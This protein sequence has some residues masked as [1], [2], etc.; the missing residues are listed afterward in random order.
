MKAFEVLRRPELLALLLAAVAAGPS[1][2]D[3]WRHAPLEV[4]SA[5]CM[6]VWLVPLGWQVMNHG[7][8]P[9]S[10]HGM[11]FT[12][13]ALGCLV[14]GGV[15]DLNFLNHCALAL[16]GAAV[17][18]QWGWR[19]LCWLAVAPAWMPVTGWLAAGWPIAP[20]VAAR[21][22]GCAVAATIFFFAKTTAADD[23]THNLLV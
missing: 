23:A 18:P 2:L 14:G 8:A 1:L 5:V 12:V 20:V 15:A 9:A 7:I 21:L 6:A 11:V 3:A 10:R 13:A 19:L 22:L 16:A 17:A 4:G